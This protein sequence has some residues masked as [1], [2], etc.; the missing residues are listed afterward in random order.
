MDYVANVT[1]DL[2][3]LLN[4]P[5]MILQRC[6][7]HAINVIKKRLVR[8]GYSKKLRDEVLNLI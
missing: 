2:I 6:E 3:E 4:R 1:K 5:A 8:K 7:K